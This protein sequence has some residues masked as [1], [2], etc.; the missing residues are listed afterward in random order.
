MTNWLVRIFL[1]LAVWFSGFSLLA[2]TTYKLTGTVRHA[3]TRQPLESVTVLKKANNRGTITN[4]A[5][6]FAILVQPNDT[7]IIRAVGFKTEQYLVH[8]RTQSDLNIDI[9][10][11]E[12]SLELPEVKVVGGLDYEKVNRALRNMKKA[13]P[14][15]VA[16]KPPPPKPLYKEK[17]SE[18]V[19]PTLENPAS[20]LYEQF[21]KE[22]KDRRK[23]AES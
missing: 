11:E 4:A 18:P 6:A 14:P 9:L 3:Q 17:K 10:L 5:G 15:K 12:G 19:A 13:P 21:S 22:G 1:F 16:V 20:L 8:P 2:Q 23:V 7:V